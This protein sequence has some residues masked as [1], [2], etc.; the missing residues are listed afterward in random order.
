[1]SDAPMNLEPAPVVVVTPGERAAPAPVEAV[2]PEDPDA[3]SA[4]D[5]PAGPHVP[6][7]ALKAVREE[8]K[9]LKER[10]GQADRLAQENAQLRPYADFVQQ[11]PQLY[12]RPPTPSITQHAADPKLERIARSLDFYTTD[13]KPDLT[14][15][16][17]HQDLV[18]DEAREMAQEVV[19]PLAM[20]TYE[21]QANTNWQRAATA[22]LPNGQPID[23][24][25]LTAAWQSVGRQNPA[26]LADERVVRIIENNVIAEQMRA[27]PLGMPAPV[28]PGRPPVVTEGQGRA[29]GTKARMNDSE[30]QLVEGRNIDDAKF[31]DLTKGFQHG[32][33][34][35]LED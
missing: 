6:L 27:A 8:N 4:V 30:R 5:L 32:R 17:A 2:V 12:Q 13:G 1:M 11:N 29:P 24:G 25:M 15:A 34:N 9:A 33:M 14:R 23:T 16:K 22:K 20:N 19:G 18:R 31:A 28:I 10:A 26:L 7:S 3:A 35:A 21:R